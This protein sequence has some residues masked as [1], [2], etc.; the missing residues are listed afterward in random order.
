MA[1]PQSQAWEGIGLACLV[2]QH[3]RSTE[4]STSGL[5]LHANSY[6]AYHD[7]AA[8][9]KGSMKPP[10]LTKWTNQGPP[11]AAGR[12]GPGVPRPSSRLCDSSALLF[13]ASSLRREG[14]QDATG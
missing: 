4:V 2:R 12:D 7:L 3:F 13:A 14:R 11:A 9:F 8:G 5:V 6:A 1:R 10:V